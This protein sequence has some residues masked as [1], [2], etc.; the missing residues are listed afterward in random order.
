MWHDG[1]PS[2]DENNVSRGCLTIHVKQM[3]ATCKGPIAS[4]GGVSLYIY[5]GKSE[6]GNPTFKN[7]KCTPVEAGSIEGGWEG[8]GSDSDSS[9]TSDTLSG[10]FQGTGFSGQ[11]MNL[12]PAAGIAG[13]S[14][15]QAYKASQAA[16]ELRAGSESFKSCENISTEPTREVVDCMKKGGCKGTEHLEVFVTSAKAAQK[17]NTISNTVED[18]Y[19]ASAAVADCGA[20][21]AAMDDKNMAPYKAPLSGQVGSFPKTVASTEGETTVDVGDRE[22]QDCNMGLVSAVAYQNAMVDESSLYDTQRDYARAMLQQASAQYAAKGGQKASFDY[23]NFEK[24]LLSKQIEERSNFFE[25]KQKLFDQIEQEYPTSDDMISN[26]QSKIAGIHAGANQA[27]QTL[28]SKVGE[29]VDMSPPSFSGTCQRVVDRESSHFF[30]NNKAKKR[31]KEIERDSNLF[32]NKLSQL[33]KVV[34]NQTDPKKLNDLL[35]NDPTY[36][37]L[38]AREKEIADHCKKE[39]CDP[40][41]SVRYADLMGKAM[42]NSVRSLMNES[43]EFVL[44]SASGLK[45]FS[46]AKPGG[47]G[48]F[49]YFNQSFKKYGRNKKGQVTMQGE[50]LHFGDPKAHKALDSTRLKQ[51]KKQV[52]GFA[53]GEILKNGGAGVLKQGQASAYLDSQRQ[54]V[55]RDKNGIL[56][57][58][59]GKAVMGHEAPQYQN[60]WEIITNRYH[61]K[62]LAD[63]Q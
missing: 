24:D 37:L 25:K 41:K 9:G 56:R 59:E 31:V 43:R 8:G 55:W 3:R 14:A 38:A 39:G 26:C 13:L 19:V 21:M 30:R 6:A 23:Y 12:L 17:D 42:P 27:F 35:E 49:S 52:K 46:S 48:S 29:Y 34:K 33:A 5:R 50:I 1:L 2:G 63:P 58:G 57:R 7:S 61:K 22:C 36:Q 18:T 32:K 53:K 28:S 54:N 16:D 4:A 51:L 10:M 45:S 47:G 11:F 15:Y 62:F 40:S 60:L 44:S 20:T